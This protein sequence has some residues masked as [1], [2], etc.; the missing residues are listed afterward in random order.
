MSPRGPAESRAE[1]AADKD[2]RSWYENTANGSRITADVYLRRLRAFCSQMGVDRA[3]IH[4]RKFKE[5]DLRDLLVRFINIETKKG[6]SGEY[7]RSTV[8]AVRSW[9]LHHG[10]RV[11]LPVKIPGAGPG[12]LSRMRR[13]PPRSSS[14]PS[15]SGRPRTSACAAP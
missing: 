5:T 2:L 7:I 10:R 14:R 1:L 9:L 8:K 13:Y 6:R 12:R 4:G 3:E 11:T 15:S